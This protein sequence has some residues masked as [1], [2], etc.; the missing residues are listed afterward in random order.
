MVY[1]AKALLQNLPVKKICGLAKKT[2]LAIVYQKN[3]AKLN[4]VQWS[5][6]SA[7]ISKEF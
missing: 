2:S 7:T 4:L 6:C 1:F 3:A 5:S